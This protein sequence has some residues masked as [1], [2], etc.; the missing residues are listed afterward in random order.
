MSA[1]IIDRT[2]EIDAPLPVVWSVIADVGRYGEWNPFV[3]ECRTSFRAGEPID[4]RVK[5]GSRVQQQSE[6]VKE[7]VPNQR[8]AYTMKPAP[9]GALHSF[10]SH[11]V[12]SLGPNRTRYRS[13]FRL[14]GWANVVV[15]ALFRDALEAG[16]A[17]MTDGIRRR[18]VELQ[19]QR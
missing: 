17:G 18:A 12:E 16:F 10:R 4:M 11:E 9:L 6:V 5:L 2:I 7:F 1:F 14:D 8:F 15:L 3:L 13:F 19:T